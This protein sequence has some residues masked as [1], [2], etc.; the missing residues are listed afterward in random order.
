MLLHVSMLYGGLTVLLVTLVGGN[1]SR[2]HLLAGAFFGG[3]VLHAVGFP[4]GS[5]VS[6]PGAVPTCLV[7]SVMG[8]CAVVLGLGG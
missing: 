6:V 4:G 3:R 1:V 8:G 7:L 5:V 2:L